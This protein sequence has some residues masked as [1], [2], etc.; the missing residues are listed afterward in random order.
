M[1]KKKTLTPAERQRRCR[2]KRKNDPEKVAEIKRKDLERY[3]ARKKLVADMSI[4][5]HRIKKRIWQERNKK[6]REKK[7][8]LKEVRLGTPTQSPTP[9]TPRMTPSAT[10]TPSATPTPS[11]VSI[12]SSRGRSYF[13]KHRPFYV[14]PPTLHGRNTCL[15]Y[16]KSNQTEIVDLRQW[17]RKSEV[18]EKAEKKVKITKNVPVTEKLTIKQVIYKFESELQNFKTHIHNIRHQYK[19]YRQCIDGLTE[20]EVALHI[21]FSENYACKYH[22]KVQSHHFGASRNQITLHTAVMYHFSAEAQKKQVTLYCTESPNQNHGPSAIWAHLHPI[23][24]E[25]K[26]KHPNVTTV[27]FFSDGPATQYKQKINFYL[28][29]GFSKNTGF[30]KYPGISLNQGMEKELPMVLEGQ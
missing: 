11:E 19:A 10:A 26:A 27:H 16:D 24:S 7:Q 23:L 2:E 13:P 22:S 20:S 5:E 25:L 30:T 4:R 28:M 8:M 15:Y 14:K 17:I 6:R 12:R 9:E 18:V 29:A 1:A 3:H 21:N